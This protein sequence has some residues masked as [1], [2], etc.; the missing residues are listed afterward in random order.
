MNSIDSNLLSELQRHITNDLPAWLEDDLYKREHQHMVLNQHA[1]VSIADRAGNITYVND[2]FCE[3]SGYAR[4]KLLG[5]NHRILK[6]GE[7]TALFYQNM[8][9]TISSGHVWQGEICNRRRDGS[10]Y[11]VASTISPFL[12]VEGSPYQYV[13]IRTDISHT[14]AL[15]SALRESEE[16]HRLILASARLGTADWNIASGQ[17]DFNERWAELRGYQ[18]NEIEHHIDSWKAGIHPDD[19]TTVETRLQEHLAGRSQFF[20]AEYR[21]YTKSCKWVWILNCSAV[22]ERD[23]A[24]VPLRMAGTEMD[25]TDRKQAEIK[26]ARST[27][28]LTDFKAALDQHA[29]VVTTDA[30]GAITYANDKFCEISKYAREE[31]IGNDHRIINSGYHPRAF[32]DELWQ[33]VS[34]GRVWKGEIKNS[35][36]DGS[37]YWVRSTI[38]PIVDVRGKPVQYIAIRADITDRK[39]AEQDMIAARDEANRAN[40]AKSQFL[41]NM[42]HELRTPMNSILGFGQLLKYSDALSGEHKDFVHEI[43]KAGDHLLKLIND[44]LDLAKVESGHIELS[45]EPVEVCSVVNECL[46]LVSTLADKRNIHMS[47]G[48]LE[49]MTVRAD[50]TRL[51]QV[52]LNLLSNAIKYNREGGSVKLKV[53]QAENNL[54]ILVTDT[55]LGISPENLKELFLPF[56]RLNAENSGIEGTGIGLTISRRIVEMMGGAVGV[57]SEVGSGTTFW[58]ELAMESAVDSLHEQQELADIKT[59]LHAQNHDAEQR[60]VLYIEDNPSNIKLVAH[61]FSQREY[62]HLLTASTPELGIE[63]ALTRHPDLILL[64]INMP[65]MNG[66]QVL[67]ALMADARLK[68]VPIVA[69]TANAMG[70]DIERGRAAGFTEYLT[71]PLNIVKFHAVLDKLLQS[72]AIEV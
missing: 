3:I 31:L 56:N 30:H 25:I 19:V 72:K 58:I 29:I 42:S 55:G 11:W 48:G 32:F 66:Y 5:H 70:R 62:I 54:R 1:I 21:T 26:Q 51:R 71:K 38:V 2:K 28:E 6:S 23:D 65:G 49:G 37:F 44:V 9:D 61:L 59:L 64:D 17:V 43:L 10:L 16:R 12:D 50:R 52:L 47:H 67:D 7:H 53:Q 63:L 40:A 41:S 27:K 35:A 34:S 36:K 69:V 8:W 57:T 45:L 4:D 68:T 33:T 39:Q 15:E 22:T 60:S 14:K 18:L 13:S 20:Q 46:S 24:G